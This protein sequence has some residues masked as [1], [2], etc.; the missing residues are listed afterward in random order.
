MTLGDIKALVVSVDPNA[1][2]Y[3]SGYTGGS[4]TCW[5]EVE[6]I[7]F[8]ADNKAQERGISFEVI[9]ITRE[10]EDPIAAALETLL[11]SYRS[12]YDFGSCLT[13]Q[14]HEAAESISVSKKIIHQKHFI[15]REQIVAAHNDIII[16]PMCE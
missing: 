13:T 5:Q 16:C 2:H 12:A 15:T 6:P 8:K 7:Y 14:V 9:R 3:F 10:E 1:R 4:Y 11:Y